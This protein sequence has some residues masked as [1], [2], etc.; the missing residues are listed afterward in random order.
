MNKKFQEKITG[1]I[2]QYKL[3]FPLQDYYKLDP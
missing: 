3:L 2:L 1:E